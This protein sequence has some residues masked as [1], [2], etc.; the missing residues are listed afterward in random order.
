MKN[1]IKILSQALSN[2]IAAG[3]VVNRPES[4]VK[5]LIENSLDAGATE[6]NLIIK[7]AGKALIQIID[8]G[9]GM[10]EE[11]ALMCFQR[12]STS[13]INEFEDLER[14]ITLGFRGEALASI[15]SVAQI[16]MKT[17]TESEELGTLIRID[18]NEVTEVSKTSCNKGTSIS[19]KNLF[20]NTPARRNFLKSN[21]TE[22]KHIY[23]TFIKIAVSKPEVSFRFQNNDE[24]IFDLKK[25]NLLNRLTD[26]FTEKFTDSLLP[27]SY[28]HNI[29]KLNGYISKPNFT[30]KAKQDQYLYLNNRMIY[31]RNLN[32]AVYSGYDD[33]I[34]KGDYPSF[35]LFID[36]LPSKVD[37]NVHPSK[38]EVKFEDE[39][40]VFG[41]IRK[42]VK[43]ALRKADLIFDVKF[44]DVLNYENQE[45]KL[46]MSVSPPS[47]KEQKF[48]FKN[49]EPTRE[50]EYSKNYS[51]GAN[52]HSI[53]EASK[54]FT[55][56]NEKLSTESDTEK[57]VIIHKTKSDEEKFNIWQYGLKYVLCQTETG[58]MIIDQHAAHE[59]ILYEKAILTLESQSSFSQQ[60]LIPINIELTN[61]DYK[62]TEELKNEFQNL[63][64]NF[65]LLDNNLLELT[66]IPSDV[67]I[68]NESKIFQE[69]IDQ[70]KDYELKLNLEKRDNLAKS[71]ACRSAIKTGD[72][73]TV[74]E[75]T[76]L[77]DNLFACKMPY[78]CPHGRPTVIRITTDELDKRF[79]RT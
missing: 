29:I 20:F 56:K 19:V 1:K 46:I 37:V 5:E 18:G 54:L 70:Y 31:S 67:R 7:D 12:H 68:G 9:T 61:I 64:F 16:E 45:E 72:R 17:K 48:S 49:N 66:G 38:H 23:E 44:E 53:L 52:I 13:K 33:L 60:L 63:G 76:N 30:K 47:N 34:D 21:H 51:S 40:A 6:I 77:I 10:N 65:R 79:S 35:F 39:S 26:I 36:I 24:I 4:V 15:C 14:L 27:V 62:I 69:L 28:E 8:N 50:R 59:R 57:N 73:L 43:E 25:N 2:K 11:D 75:M 78:V 55:E 3:E 32:F 58:L 22:F 42:G 71:Y 74:P 41:F